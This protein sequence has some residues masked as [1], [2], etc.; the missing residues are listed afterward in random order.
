MTQPTFTPLT[1]EEIKALP[2]SDLNREL[3]RTKSRVFYGEN[4]A[5][6]G[7]IMSSMDFVWSYGVKTAATNGETFWWNPLFFLQ[8][9]PNTRETVLVHELWHAALLHM[10]RMGNR[11]PKIWNYACDIRINNGLENDSFSFVGVEN[12]WKDQ[13][14][15]LQAEEDIYDQLYQ[16]A[17]KVVTPAWGPGP[18]TP[19][20]SGS[21]GQPNLP[22][23]QGQPG[24]QGG[25]GQ[26][27]PNGLPGDGLGDMVPTS[28][29]SNAAAINNVVRAIHQA[30]QAGQ[31]GTIPGGLEEIIEKF[32]KSVV[33]WETL[34]Q[35]WMQDLL[36]EDYTWARP[37]RR[38]SDIYL[39]SRIENEGR[40]E[41]LIFY[42]DTSGS[43]TPE[44]LLRTNSEIKHIWDT[45]KPKKLTTV[46]FDTKIQKIDVFNDGDQYES[47]I[48]KGRGGTCLIPVRQHIIDEK[49]TAVVIFSDLYVT[50]MQ[51]LPFEIPVLWATISKGVKVPFGQLIHIRES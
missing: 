28:P 44:E 17:V 25:N 32:L 20:G 42:Q 5:F 23:S 2:I 31:A 38:Y 16:K 41:H 24:Q 45:M 46:Q 9:D 36:E 37:N 47:M 35:R 15:G 12:C 18:C 3:D 7:S 11:D 34:L 10:I 30:K 13:S 43:M 39:P 50:P 21:Q 27:D 6:L 29:A 26:P 1:E 33:P 51:E 22:G 14:Y 40:L 49:P 8:L 48:V 4:S 19:N